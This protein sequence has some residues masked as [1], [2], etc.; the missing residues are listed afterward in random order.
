MMGRIWENFLGQ[1]N[2]K[3]SKNQAKGDYKDIPNSG[4]QEME[5]YRSEKEYL[6]VLELPGA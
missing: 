3:N 2:L 1:L 6:M 5:R 4:G